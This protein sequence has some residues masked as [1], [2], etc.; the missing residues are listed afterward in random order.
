FLS[1]AIATGEMTSSRGYD[2]L[3]VTRDGSVPVSVIAAPIVDE[4][5][6]I[7]AVSVMRDVSHEREVD[8]MKTSLV[9]TVSHEL[10][11]PLTM[12]QGFSELLLSRELPPDKARDALEQINASSDRLSSLI[13]DLLSVS[14]IEAGSLEVRREALDVMGVV[15]EAVRPFMARA[16]IAVSAT[17]PPP[18]VMADR[19]MLIQILTNL[20]SNAV[21]YSSD[22]S[23]VAVTVR[24]SSGAVAIEVADRG[25][26]MDDREVSR[27]FTK[28]F[29]SEREEVRNAPGTGLGLYIT[30]SLVEMQGGRI[31]VASE[32][33]EGTTFTVTLPME[34]ARP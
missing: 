30:R 32:L 33:G 6:I 17:H 3:L 7:G 18:P 2:H 23:P 14:K 1:Q 11:T 19:A 29:R 13:D 31:E 15:E 12:I 34:E 24:P 16:N 28:F 26:G 8:E 25:V 20:I 5:R 4:G 21:K 10:R 27:L 9:S 22:G